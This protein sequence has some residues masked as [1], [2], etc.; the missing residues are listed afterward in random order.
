MVFV[1]MSINTRAA[2][3]SVSVAYVRTWV[4]KDNNNKKNINILK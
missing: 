2:R 1:R 4:I 3:I